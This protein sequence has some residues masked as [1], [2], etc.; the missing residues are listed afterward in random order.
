MSATPRSAPQSDAPPDA[1][2][3]PWRVRGASL[4]DCGQIASAVARLLVELG[5]T[6]PDAAAMRATTQALLENPDQGAIVVAEADDALVGVL[7]A[8]WQ[9]AIHIPGRYALIQ[10]LWVHQ[11]R[12]S[13]AIGAA[14]LAALF[15]LARQQRIERVEVGL[16]RDGFA[17]LD[18]TQAFYERNGFALH[19]PRM[20]LVLS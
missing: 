20:R 6:P 19:G 15:A 17:G 11:A 2:A 13:N 3:A 8:S 10:D 16:P 7:A 5:G 9:T 18:A 4:E 12:R 1:G 14:L